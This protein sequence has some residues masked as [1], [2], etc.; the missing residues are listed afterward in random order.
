MR[1][2]VDNGSGFCFGVVRAIR[3]AEEAVPIVSLG[4]IVHNA[5]EVARLEG[6]GME[7]APEGTDLRD[8]A[9]RRALVRAHGEPPAT[10]EEAE[11]HGVE[12]V[13]ATCPVVAA[14]QKTVAEA[15]EAMR[16]VGGQVVIFGRAGHAEVRGLT[17]HAEG[18]IVIEGEADLERVDFGKPIYLLAQTTASLGEFRR[19]GAEMRR[20]TE[21]AGGE[22]EIHDTVCRQVADREE[23]LAEFARRHDVCLFVAGAKSS[24]G[25]VLFEAVKG[26]NPRSHKIE[27]PDDVRGEWLDGADSVGVCGATSTPRWLMEQV[28]EKI[29]C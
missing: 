25:R 5:A 10:Y 8:L 22:V 18:A 14:L 11:E 17:G 21:E 4:D 23:R 28:A 2:E 6:L 20:R 3:M 24:N 27:G 26:A 16:R 29:C 12:L 7:T 9:G 1:I 13:D 19:L 15:W